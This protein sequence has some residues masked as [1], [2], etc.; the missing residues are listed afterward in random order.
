[1][2]IVGVIAEYNPFHNGHQFHI[3]KAKE[4][5][6]ADAVIVVMSGNFVQRGVPAIMPKYVRTTSA[7][8]EGASMVIELP[9]C[10]AT[11]TAEQFALGAVSILDKLG[12]VDAICFGSECGNITTLQTLSDVLFEEPAEYKTALQSALRSGLSFPAA[13]Q[14]AMKALYPEQDMH[15][16]LEHPNN[17]LAIEYL[18]A[19]RKL[20]S[21]I[22]PLTIPRQGAG[23]HDPQLQEHYSSASAIR[24]QILANSYEEIKSQIPKAS[25]ELYKEYF[26][27]HSSVIS[28]DCSLL[29]KYKLLSE[30]KE[31]LMLYSDVSEELA[32]RICNC[33][34]NYV[35]FNQFCELLKT[36]EVTYSRI[37][38]ALLHIIL[39]IKKTHLTEIEYARVLGFCQ[40]DVSIFTD[41][42]NS[43][44]LSLV[45]QSAD[46]Q[47]LSS[48][49]KQ[50]L[51]LDI[52]AANV[53]E[54]LV[55]YKNH[56]PYKNE[57][58]HPMIRI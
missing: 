27:T 45:S 19:L 12:C 49:G 41:I 42:K 32:N 35:C 47:Y 52:Y 48:K 33:K 37:S 34:N 56:T 31:S 2:K 4:L 44:S 17:I 9:V 26:Q 21:N 28:D 24:T 10:Y 51:D 58:E 3:Q 13:R 20:N 15:S 43:T 18:K 53:Y 55:S 8:Q 30:T 29:L 6:C 38:R 16:I 36:K 11:G 57:F 1:M 5:A 54:S 23:Y 39:G 40:K 14:T 50:M 25:F 46:V 7:L 22:I